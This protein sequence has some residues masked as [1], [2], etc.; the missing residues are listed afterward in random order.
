MTARPPD[1]VHVGVAGAMVADGGG[2]PSSTDSRVGGVPVLPGAGPPVGWTR[3]ACGVCGADMA[4]VLQ[5]SVCV[6]VRGALGPQG[7]LPPP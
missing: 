2:P 6:C 5:V 3:P 1:P 7:V 4:L